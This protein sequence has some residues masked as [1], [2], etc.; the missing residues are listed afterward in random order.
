V[1]WIPKYR[2]KALYAELRKYLGPV[3]RDLVR[4]SLHRERA[5]RSIVNT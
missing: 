3:F 1:V 4:V 5:D 2:R